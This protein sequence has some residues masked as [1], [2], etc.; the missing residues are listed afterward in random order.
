MPETA[1]AVEQKRIGMLNFFS[2][3]D[4]DRPAVARGRVKGPCAALLD[5][6]IDPTGLKFTLNQDGSVTV[7]G[8]VRNET[9]RERICRILGEMNLADGIR[10]NMMIDA[11]GPAARPVLE[12]KCG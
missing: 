10:N 12:K 1:V 11:T 9:E 3:T 4:V 2:K 6:G 7:T 8:Q 5:H